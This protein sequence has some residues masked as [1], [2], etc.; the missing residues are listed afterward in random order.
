MKMIADTMSRL[1][2]VPAPRTSTMTTREMLTVNVSALIQ[3]KSTKEAAESPNG[4]KYFDICEEGIAF[5]NMMDEEDILIEEDNM[6]EE[7]EMEEG[8]L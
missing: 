2:M 7:W 8:D 6:T 3:P 1:C 5:Y 4:I